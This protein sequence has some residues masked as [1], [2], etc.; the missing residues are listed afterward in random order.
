LKVAERSRILNDLFKANKWIAAREVILEWLKQEPDDHWALTRLSS[1]YAEEGNFV[2]ALEL[3]EHA[4]KI[5]PRC[6][7]AL[8]DYTEALYMNNRHDEAIRICKNLI[9]RGAKRIAYG[10]YGQG[11]RWSRSLIN[12]RRYTLGLL[13]GSL[14]EYHLAAKFIKLHI[15]NRNGNCPSVYKLREVKEDLSAILDRKYPY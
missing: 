15:A 3:I 10:K 11:I 5:E 14:G 1:T 2:K 9:R 6:P 8:S 4:L 13:Y 12:D 7:L